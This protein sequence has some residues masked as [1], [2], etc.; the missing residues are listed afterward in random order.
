MWNLVVVRIFLLFLARCLISLKYFC[1]HCLV[2]LIFTLNPLN[3]V[4]TRF[5]KHI[6]FH[7]Q[8]HVQEHDYVLHVLYIF[9]LWFLILILT[10]YVCLQLLSHQDKDI[11]FQYMSVGR[12]FHTIGVMIRELILSWVLVLVFY[13]NGRVLNTALFSR[14]L[15]FGFYFQDWKKWFK[16]HILNCFNRFSWF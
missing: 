1:F 8:W 5:L 13:R 9:D 6:N 15:M 16:I 4:A 7:F 12:Y 10:Q 2:K 11:H 14:F 3:S